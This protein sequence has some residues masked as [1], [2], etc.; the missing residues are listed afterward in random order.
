M[1]KH[2][3]RVISSLRTRIHQRRRR[4]GARR[5]RR[6]RIR[7][8]ERLLL[9]RVGSAALVQSAERDANRSTSTTATACTTASVTWHVGHVLFARE[10]FGRSEVGVRE[11]CALGYCRGFVS[12]RGCRRRGERELFRLIAQ[13]ELNVERVERDGEQRDTGELQTGAARECLQYW[14]AEPSPQ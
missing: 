4:R 6:R 14:R 13:H 3:I 12:I 8:D 11:R 10:H 2:N 5:R 7:S 1:V 9:L